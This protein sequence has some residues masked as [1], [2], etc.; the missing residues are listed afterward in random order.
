MR[1]SY[2]SKNS[3]AGYGCREA[4]LIDTRVLPL[5]AKRNNISIAASQFGMSE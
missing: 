4:A 5:I 2:Q 3:G 1:Q